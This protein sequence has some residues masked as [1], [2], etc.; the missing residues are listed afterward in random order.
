[1]ITKV[2][3]D[4]DLYVTMAAKR[5]EITNVDPVDYKRI[6]IID[7]NGIVEKPIVINFSKKENEVF[8]VYN[9]QISYVVI[10]ATEV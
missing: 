9:Y 10:V 8:Y 5:I 6:V 2:N 4:I 7:D 1:M 3:F